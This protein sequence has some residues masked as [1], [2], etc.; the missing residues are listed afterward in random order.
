LCSKDSCVVNQTF[1]FQIKFFGKSPTF[2]VATNCY[3]LSK[4]CIENIVKFNLIILIFISS[5]SL[6]G[7]NKSTGTP[8]FTCF[9]KYDDSCLGLKFRYD[10]EW[11][12]KNPNINLYGKV[13]KLIELNYLIK[14]SNSEYQYKT[15]MLFDLNG[16]MVSNSSID[17]FDK[18]H[19]RYQYF[20]NEHTDLITL[21]NFS[22][23]DTINC[24]SKHTFYR[25]QNI[26]YQ[27]VF[28]SQDKEMLKVTTYYDSQGY[29]QKSIMISDGLNRRDTMFYEHDSI[30]R[31]T[32]TIEK[33]NYSGSSETAYL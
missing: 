14:N 21:L 30:G 33:T 5:F 12:L 11:S 4:I 31:N 27:T 17:K 25:D 15:I 10:T 26:V 3:E 19:N 6:L 18:V 28:N 29:K 23:Y 22:N 2:R 32:K 9:R 1:V 13:K 20:Y 8:N 7:Q 16:Y 24:A